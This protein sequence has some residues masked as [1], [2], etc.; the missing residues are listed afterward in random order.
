MIGNRRCIYLAEGECEEKLIS[1]LKEQPALIVPG[2]IKKLNAV[3]E[4]LTR[5]ILMTFAPGSVV[6]LVFDTDVE[7]TDILKKTFAYLKNNAVEYGL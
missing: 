6:I 2:K 3:Q 1:A 4:E 7:M 5:S